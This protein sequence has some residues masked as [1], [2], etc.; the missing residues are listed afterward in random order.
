[1]L[2][3]NSAVNVHDSQAYRNMDMTWER[4]SFTFDPKDIL[5]SI[6]TG[7][8]FVWAAVVC[9]VLERITA[10]CPLNINY[11]SEAFSH[12]HVI[13]LDVY[14]SHLRCAMSIFWM[15]REVPDYSNI[16][17]IVTP[18]SLASSLQYIIQSSPN[19]KV[20]LPNI[21]EVFKIKNGTSAQ[22]HRYLI[23]PAEQKARVLLMREKSS[24]HQKGPKR[25]FGYR[26]GILFA[27]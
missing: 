21:P 10:P 7:F 2:F 13:N 23:K 6:Q 18:K 27:I 1:M 22:L 25:T 11:C 20:V 12:Q 19:L 3:S 5:L 8:S 17:S 26:K 24:C 15:V 9:S 4:I 14:M 16:Q